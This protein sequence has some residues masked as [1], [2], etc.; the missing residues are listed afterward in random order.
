MTCPSMAG[1]DC[2]SYIEQYNSA[3]DDISRYFKSYARC[4]SS[5]EGKDDCSLEFRRLKSAQSEFEDAVSGIG[6]YCKQ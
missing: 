2:K 1:Y 4:V 5:S 6:L 3:V